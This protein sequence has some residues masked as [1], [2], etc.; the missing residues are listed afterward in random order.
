M[1]T[2]PSTATTE[3]PPGNRGRHADQRTRHTRT[4]PDLAVQD[5]TNALDSCCCRNLVAGKWTEAVA[6]RPKASR[7]TC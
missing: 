1:A 5:V 6:N 2:L 7:P 4:G 3:Q